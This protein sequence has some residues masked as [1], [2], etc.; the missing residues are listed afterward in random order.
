MKGKSVFLYVYY[1]KINCQ[2]SFKRYYITSLLTLFIKSFTPTSKSHLNNLFL[3]L[4]LTRDQKNKIPFEVIHVLHLLI[5][6][7]ILIVLQMRKETVLS[8]CFSFHFTWNQKKLFIIGWI[9]RTCFF[10][11]ILWCYNSMVFT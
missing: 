11:R 7:Y 8:R 3:N 6:F 9:E 5:R 4:I 2:R 10:R 1:E